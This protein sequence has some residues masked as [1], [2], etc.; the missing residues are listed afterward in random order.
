M[1]T[2]VEEI[3]RMSRHYLE[4]EVGGLC[5][6]NIS[7]SCNSYRRDLCHRRQIHRLPFGY[8]FIPEENDDRK[9]NNGSEL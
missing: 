4:P 7:R 3:R 1:Y 2:N 6:L 8:R 5:R 9:R